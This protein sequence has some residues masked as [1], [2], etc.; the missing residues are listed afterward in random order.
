MPNHPIRRN[1]PLSYV[2]PICNGMQALS[3]ECP[4]CRSLVQDYGRWLDYLGP[5][6]P[7]REI[8]DLSMTDGFS[9]TGEEGC[10]HLVNCPECGR[11]FTV[12]IHA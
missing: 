2:C 7:Y 8:D 3:A 6:S 4:E 1:T 5:Y 9:G 11:S 10:V 12:E